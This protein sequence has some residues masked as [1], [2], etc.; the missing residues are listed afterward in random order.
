MPPIALSTKVAYQ[1]FWTSPPNI[2]GAE[3]NAALA[4]ANI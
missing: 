3:T 4:T 1:D 2:L